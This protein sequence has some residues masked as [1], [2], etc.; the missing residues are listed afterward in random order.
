[1]LLT[2]PQRAV[3]PAGA[4]AAA[5]PHMNPF[6]RKRGRGCPGRQCCCLSK[7]QRAAACVLSLHGMWNEVPDR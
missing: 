6:T 1:L 2:E 7:S 4:G 3:A 5:A